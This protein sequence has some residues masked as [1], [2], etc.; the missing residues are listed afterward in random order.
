VFDKVGLGSQGVGVVLQVLSGYFMR[1]LNSNLVSEVQVSLDLGRR[2]I[3][4]VLGP[5]RQSDGVCWRGPR[6]EFFFM[7]FFVLK[8]R[9]LGLIE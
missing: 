5:R 2:S 4:P 3:D 8:P 1:P 9:S 7:N 6:H